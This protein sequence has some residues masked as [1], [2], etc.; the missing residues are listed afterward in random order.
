VYGNDPNVGRIVGALGNYLAHARI[1]TDLDQL[2][3][4]IAGELVFSRGCFHLDR[5]KEIT[6]SSYL[7]QAAM[8]PRLRGYPQHDLCV[9]VSVDFGAG[10]AESIVWG[11]DLSDEYVHENADYRT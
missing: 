4:R 9:D 11:S 10:A 5:E 1:H 8:N 7:S 6:L 2:E 3:I